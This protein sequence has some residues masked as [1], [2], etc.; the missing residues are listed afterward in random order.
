MSHDMDSIA[1]NSNG[2]HVLLVDKGKYLVNALMLEKQN[3]FHLQYASS[4]K[5]ALK[6]LTK[7][8][9]HICV[10]SYDIPD[11]D[12]LALIKAIKND[13]YHLPIL[14]LI[15]RADN[16]IYKKACSSKYGPFHVLVLDDEKVPKIFSEL[17]Q[18]TQHSGPR[19]ASK[20]LKSYSKYN[21]KWKTSGD[22]SRH[23]IRNNQLKNIEK[24]IEE[25]PGFW[26]CKGL[27][28]HYDVT[29]Q[30]ISNDIQELK[31]RGF[32]IEKRAQGGYFFSKD[33]N[34]IKELG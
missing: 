32:K 8:R 25:K 34:T 24:K 3:G 16:E 15:N 21:K 23:E 10:L 31:S 11:M 6:C 33:E 17:D 30:Q 26:T 19:Y 18:C 28:I 14:L 7:H 29:P 5:T 27:S 20:V 2:Y 12:Y 13:Y 4:G 22:L 9:F 1:K